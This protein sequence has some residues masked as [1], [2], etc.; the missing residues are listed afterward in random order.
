MQGDAL[1]IFADYKLFIVKEEGETSQLCQAYNKDVS[2]SYK[3][4]HH[5]FLNGIRMAVNVVD[6]YALIF[7]SN[8]VSTLCA[9]FCLSVAN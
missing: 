2:L 9:L 7:V 5:Y 3:R 4:H 6:Q 8:K 1:K